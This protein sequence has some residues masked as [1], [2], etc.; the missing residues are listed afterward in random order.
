M[1]RGTYF[2]D[3]IDGAYVFGDANNRC[4][5]VSR[6]TNVYVYSRENFWHDMVKTDLLRLPATWFI[7]LTVTPTICACV[8]PT[9]VKNSSSS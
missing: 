7:I 4:V 8:L 3:L 9:F 6:V 1:Y 5:Y 2:A